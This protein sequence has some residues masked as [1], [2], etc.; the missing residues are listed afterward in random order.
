MLRWIGERETER[1]AGAEK[2]SEKHSGVREWIGERER[3]RRARINCSGSL[4]WNKAFGTIY[5]L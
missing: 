3:E 1:R 5:L 4:S 2:E